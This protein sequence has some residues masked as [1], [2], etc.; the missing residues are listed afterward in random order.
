M[1]A[2]FADKNPWVSTVLGMGKVGCSRCVEA[3]LDPQRERCEMRENEGNE[4][5]HARSF[6]RSFVRSFR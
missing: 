4:E 2:R 5:S 6:V 1:L 3:V